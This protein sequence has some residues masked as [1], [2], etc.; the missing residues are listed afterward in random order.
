MAQFDQL[1][2]LITAVADPSRR[3]ILSA[4]RQNPL[5]VGTLVEM[6]PMTQPGVTKHLGVL[7]KAGLITRRAEGRMRIC[8]LKAEGLRPL[9]AWLSDYRRLW[10]DPL[11]DLAGPA[12]ETPDD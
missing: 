7:E 3:Q 8:E 9:D 10:A 6:L 12:E 4:L 2:H 5:P 1:S 11:D